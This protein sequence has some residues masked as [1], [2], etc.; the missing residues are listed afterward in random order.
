MP[1]LLKWNIIINLCRKAWPQVNFI[2]SFLMWMWYFAEE[3][4]L[5]LASHV[6][7]LSFRI[8]KICPS[9]LVCLLPHWSWGGGQRVHQSNYCQYR[10]VYVRIWT[11]TVLRPPRSRVKRVIRVSTCSARSLDRWQMFTQTHN[12]DETYTL[13]L[14]RHQPDNGK[15]AVDAARHLQTT[16]EGCG[17][18]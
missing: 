9:P 18:T 12:G 15:E 8:F 7:I 11:I 5:L 4:R 6:A 17:G 10:H 1:A 3:R 14:K 2:N 13:C 16:T